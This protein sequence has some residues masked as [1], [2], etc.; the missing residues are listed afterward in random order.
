MISKRLV[1]MNNYGKRGFIRNKIKELIDE[2]LFQM[3]D[4]QLTDQ[5][6]Y[7]WIDYSRQVIEIATKDY[8]PE[9]LLNYLRVILSIRPQLQPYQK[10]GLCL[11]YLIGVLK[12][13]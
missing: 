3:R 12:I 6:S 9:I 10:I 11:D 2:G 7:V 4:P 1:M 13:L 8:N 5:M